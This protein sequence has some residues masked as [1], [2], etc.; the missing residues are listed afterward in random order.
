MIDDE[1]AR[2]ESLGTH[3][4]SLGEKAALVCYTKHLILSLTLSANTQL[5][6]FS[7]YQIGRSPCDLQALP[8]EQAAKVLNTPHPP[9]PPP[10]GNAYGPICRG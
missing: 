3:P 1:S 2:R 4:F 6:L 10:L 7:G 9:A 5:H 8:K